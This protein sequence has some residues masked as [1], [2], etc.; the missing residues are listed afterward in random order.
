MFQLPFNPDDTVRYTGRRFARDL[1]GLVGR[2][3]ARV[4]GSSRSYVTEFTIAVK[5]GVRLESYVLDATSL[6]RFTPTPK[7]QKQLQDDMQVALLKNKLESNEPQK[8]KSRRRTV[9]VS[10]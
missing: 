8:K 1:H 4:A 2:V 9:E 3:V 5:D 10:S 6:E 7:E